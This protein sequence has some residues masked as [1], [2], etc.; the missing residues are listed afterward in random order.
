MLRRI[1]W[2]AIYSAGDRVKSALDFRWTE[3]PAA[4]TSLVMN[5]GGVAG[6]R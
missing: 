6:A 2:P 1:K 3:V 4:V 5:V